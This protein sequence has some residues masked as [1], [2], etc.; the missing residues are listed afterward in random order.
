MHLQTSREANSRS[1]SQHV[2]RSLCSQKAEYRVTSGA[3]TM[4]NVK[5]SI[6]LD[7]SQRSLVTGANVSQKSAASIIRILSS[8]TRVHR[9]Y[10]SWARWI[11]STFSSKIYNNII[12]YLRLCLSTRFLTHIFDAFLI[13]LLRAIRPVISSLIR[14]I[15]GEEHKLWSWSQCYFRQLPV[16]YIY[17]NRHV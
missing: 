7:V 14:I 10:S 15:F 1:A 4:E 16:N 17:K 12:R 5:I 6:F 13:S 11:Q 2:P 9:W 8:I 3:L